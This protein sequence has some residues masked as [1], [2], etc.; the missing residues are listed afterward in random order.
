MSSKH[1]TKSDD[2]NDT[3]IDLTTDNSH[4]LKMSA[5]PSNH[6]PRPRRPRRCRV[7]FL[8]PSTKVTDLQLEEQEGRTLENRRVCTLILDESNSPN[9]FNG[10]STRA[11]DE[12]RGR[13]NKVPYKSFTTPAAWLVANRWVFLPNSPIRSK[14]SN[15]C[16]D[17][18]RCKL[19][20]D[21]AY[22]K[23]K[24]VEVLTD[25]ELYEARKSIMKWVVQKAGSDELVE[26]IIGKNLI[27]FTE[28]Y[29]YISED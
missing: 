23:G 10:T 29:G 16:P 26:F 28:F 21:F 4:H 3:T 11:P 7:N 15:K 13:L 14:N 25:V 1:I 12:A 18:V 17:S 6:K 24:E 19:E 5:E 9:F 8:C 20:S 2:L 22:M 27:D